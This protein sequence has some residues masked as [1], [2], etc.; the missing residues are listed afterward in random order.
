MTHYFAETMGS[1]HSSI[2]SARIGLPPP[3]ENNSRCQFGHRSLLRAV[4]LTVA[5]VNVKRRL[6]GDTPVSMF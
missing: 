4:V 5:L 2:K 1:G 3:P 6:F